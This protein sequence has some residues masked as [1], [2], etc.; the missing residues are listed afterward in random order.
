MERVVRGTPG[1]NLTRQIGK[2]SPEGNGLM[3]MLGI[4]GTAI[5]PAVALASG[6]GF[7]AKRASDGIAQRNIDD[8]IRL[9][10]TGKPIAPKNTRASTIVQDD[11]VQAALARMGVIGAL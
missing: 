5:N 7:V 9:V 1:Q 10:R 4:G 6:G 8:L 2:L 3:A 11:A